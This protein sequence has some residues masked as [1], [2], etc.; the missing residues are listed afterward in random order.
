LPWH[1]PKDLRRFRTRT[2]GKPIIM[3]R[4]TFELIGKPLPGRFTIVLTSDPEYSASGCRLAGTFQ[5][6]LCIAEEYL[7]S[8]GGDEVMIGGGGKVYAE[9]I[10]RWDRCYLTVV[11][12]EFKG[13]KYFPV[14]EFLRQPW[15]PAC[16]PEM[17]PSDENNPHPHSFHVIQRV[18]DAARPSPRLDEGRLAR[19]CAYP[20]EALDGL[21][22]A[23]IM[24]R[25]TVAS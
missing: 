23:A 5:E 12:G 18:R 21:D 14:G 20:R 9:A 10:H 15:R 22:L 8:A 4:T 2:W 3:G 13:S 16:E 7:A 25:G 24:R 19:T 1:L 6:A 11:E 17:H